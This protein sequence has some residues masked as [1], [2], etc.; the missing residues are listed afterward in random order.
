M[1]KEEINKFVLINDADF[2]EVSIVLTK[3]PR[4]TYNI[5][6]NDNNENETRYCYEFKTLEEAED[7]FKSMYQHIFIV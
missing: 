7:F 3:N 6:I 5:D 1:I 2:G 4:G